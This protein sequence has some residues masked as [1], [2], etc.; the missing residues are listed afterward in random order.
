MVASKHSFDLNMPGSR[1]E[2][3]V[4]ASVRSESGRIGSVGLAGAT[5][6]VSPRSLLCELYPEGQRT[7]PKEYH[8]PKQ[9]RTLPT[10]V[11]I[12]SD[13]D[14]DG[15]SLDLWHGSAANAYVFVV[16]VVLLLLLLLFWGGW[17]GVGVW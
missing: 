4:A 6:A 9:K 2:G 14:D 1:L 13:S 8:I 7:S 17:V 12:E 5:G 16:V 15:Q 10:F 3:Q 11:G